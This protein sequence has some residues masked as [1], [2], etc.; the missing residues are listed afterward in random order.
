[1]Q[2]GAKEAMVDYAKTFIG[3]PYHWGGESSDEGFDCSGF[4]QE[5]LKSVGLD[6]R[7]DQTSD[8]LYRLFQREKGQSNRMTPSPSDLVF[9]GSEAKVTH[10]AMAINSSQ[11]IEAAGEGSTPTKKGMV[12]V[13]P[14]NY[15]SDLVSIIGVI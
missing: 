12:R 6:P 3:T 1:M 14:I 10:I 13:R 5:I 2:I 8:N 11:I 9:Y 7:G 4:V 15:R